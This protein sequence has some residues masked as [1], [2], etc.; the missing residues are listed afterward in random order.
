MIQINKYALMEQLTHDLD[1]NLAFMSLVA[2]CLDDSLPA[3]QRYTLSYQLKKLLTQHSLISYINEDEHASQ[4][5]SF[6]LKI[7]SVL[8]SHKNHVQTNF[9][10]SNSDIDS[11]D[12]QL[13]NTPITNFKDFMP[14]VAQFYKNHATAQNS[15]KLNVEKIQSIINDL[16]AQ[17]STQH[18]GE[19]IEH[20]DL[21][22]EDTISDIENKIC[23]ITSDVI[24]QMHEELQKVSPEKANKIRSYLEKIVPYKSV[25]EVVDYNVFNTIEEQTPNFAEAIRFIKGNFV[26]NNSRRQQENNYLVPTPI[27]LLG[28]PGIGKTHF[29]QILAKQLGT[30][31]HF[32][33]SNSITASWVLTGSSGQW[34][35]A[36]S[37]AIF[38]IMLE[39][40]TVSPIV[41]FDEIDKLSTGKNYD[42]YSTF[43]QLLEPTNAK[44]FKDEF[45]NAKFDASN[46]IYILTANDISNIPKSLV[47]RMKVFHISQANASET[48]KIAQ[49]M[50]ADIIGKS[51]LFTPILS[52]SNLTTLEH[53]VPRD[54]KK[55]LKEA[56]FNQAADLIGLSEQELI[57]NKQIINQQKWGF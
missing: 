56:V 42:P 13:K 53:L 20:L 47:S 22:L 43:H 8:N 33:D 6:D 44:I 10:H 38:K 50:Y 31:F 55:I 23:W 15:N 5:D 14:A 46:M 51:Q 26:L 3:L 29:A 35:N 27:L 40:N 45:L 52:E 24:E 17:T 48:R 39:S 4:K 25:I 7:E 18:S 34:Q 49:H 9:L 21:K 16:V 1:F 30:H 2:G 37:G 32:F 19:Q 12:N 11:I 41:I 54:I 36:D 28:D 57:I